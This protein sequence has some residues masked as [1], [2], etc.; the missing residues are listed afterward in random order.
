MTTAVFLLGTRED[1]I[2]IADRE[3]SAPLREVSVKMDAIS[4]R[5]EDLRTDIFK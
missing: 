3:H 4:G 1:P 2:T 5:V